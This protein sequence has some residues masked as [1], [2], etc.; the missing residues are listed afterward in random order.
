M[1]KIKIYDVNAL[2]LKE[3]NLEA[4]RY[5]KVAIFEGTYGIIV[6]EKEAVHQVENM[7]TDSISIEANTPADEKHIAIM[8]NR[9]CFI[10]I[11]NILEKAAFEEMEMSQFFS[12]SMYNSR[13]RQ[14][15]AKLMESLNEI[16]FDLKEYI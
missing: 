1:K 4:F 7:I 12:G 3:D 6:A 14:N 13:C 9:R 15:W 2:L 16:E 10:I 8:P 5:K 11:K